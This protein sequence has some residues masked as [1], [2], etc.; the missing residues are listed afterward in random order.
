MGRLSKVA[1]IILI[2]LEVSLSSHGGEGYAVASMM[3]E[4]R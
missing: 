3:K 1:S 2:M 4:W